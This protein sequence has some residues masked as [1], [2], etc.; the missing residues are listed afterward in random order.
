VRAEP[1]AERLVACLGVRDGGDGEGG[2]RKRG[3]DA[4]DL[5]RV[6]TRN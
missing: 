2:E 6:W 1:R 3:T 5:P 4:H